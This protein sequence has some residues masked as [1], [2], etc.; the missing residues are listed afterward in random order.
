MRH[1]VIIRLC[2]P[3]VSRPAD[4]PVG[5]SLSALT[6]AVVQPAT[7]LISVLGHLSEA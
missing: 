4:R 1:G 5:S 7:E 6:G 2:D 3:I